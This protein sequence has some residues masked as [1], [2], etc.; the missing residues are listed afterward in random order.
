MKRIIKDN[1]KYIFLFIFF[2]CCL[3]FFYSMFSNDQ[4]YNYGFSYALS[5]GEI[6]Y[7]DFNMIIPPVG[8]IIYALPM[9]LFG[10]NLIIFNLYQSL[11]LCVL[12][13][14]LFKLFNKKAYL[15]LLGLI[16]T[17]PI[18]VVTTIF[19]GYNFL[20]LLELVM[21]LYL[22][23]IKASDY[24]I[25]FLLGIAV[26]TKQTVGVGLC[27]VSLYYLFKD[28][29]KVL[30]RIVGFLIP[31]FMFLIYFLVTDTLVDFFDM[32]LFGMFDFTNKNSSLKLMFLEFYFYI[33][34]L[35][36]VVLI[37]NILK[38]KNNLMYYYLLAYALIAVPL[39]DYNHV[40]YFTFP[41]LF[42]FINKINLKNE[43]IGFHFCFSSLAFSII[44]F[45]FI[46]NFKMPHI[47]NYDNFEC[48]VANKWYAEEIESLQ[49]FFKEKP[50]T[51]LLSENTYIVKMSLNLDL[52]HYDLLNYGNHG[53]NGTK[54]LIDRLEKEKDKYILINM[55]AYNK[56]GERQQ[57]N[58]DVMKFVIENYEKKGE[59]NGYDIYYKK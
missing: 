4:I 2:F 46:F 22:E 9:F 58:K 44:W 33:F 43:K 16:L 36:I 56:M 55:M 41:L 39:F 35:E 18:P 25:G 29:K 48:F 15:L 49:D 21:L 6:P 38:D 47:A 31:C 12:F 7:K 3:Q 5:R 11:L 45:L 34:L 1:Y 54:K 50:N 20:L 13:Y 10:T 23:K 27:L 52:N 24:L 14:F 37:Y 59:L 40:S 17:I 32:C 19:Q 57:I 28:Y 42:I 8:P 51:I 53:Y 30:K 26:F